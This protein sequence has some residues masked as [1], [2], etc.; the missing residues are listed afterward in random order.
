MSNLKVYIRRIERMMRREQQM[1]RREQLRRLG[2]RT[3]DDPEPVDV[4]EVVSHPMPQ[5]VGHPAAVKRLDAWMLE[6]SLTNHNF[7]KRSGISVRTLSRF[8]KTGKLGKTTFALLAQVLN[9]TPEELQKPP[10]KPVATGREMAEQ[11]PVFYRQ[12][13]A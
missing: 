8:R 7:A 4:A 11:W 2:M 13:D 1:M 9:T 6:R 12:D 5:S 10:V 3:L